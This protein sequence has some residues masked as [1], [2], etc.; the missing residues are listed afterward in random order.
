MRGASSVGAHAMWIAPN[1]IMR[2]IIVDCRGTAEGC[3]ATPSAIFR[4]AFCDHSTSVPGGLS[5]MPRPSGQWLTTDRGAHPRSSGLG[6]RVRG[7]SAL[8]P[9]RR[10]DG[11]AAKRT[12]CPLLVCSKRCLDRHCWQQHS[13]RGFRAGVRKRLKM[14]LGSRSS[15]ATGSTRSRAEAAASPRRV[16]PSA[17]RPTRRAAHQD[18]SC[19]TGP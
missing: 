15:T 8:R 5:L 17:G 3:A 10:W 4:R 14:K 19:T 18:R 1:Q 6:V 2:P 11:H 13:V 16:S 7:G 12:R 9:G